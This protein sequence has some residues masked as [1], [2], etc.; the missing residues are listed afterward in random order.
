[1]S[2]GAAPSDRNDNMPAICVKSDRRWGILST[3]GTQENPWAPRQH[4]NGVLSTLKYAFLR[5]FPVTLKAVLHSSICS[6]IV[7]F[8]SRLRR[9]RRL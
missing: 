9:L 7:I 5:S 2:I 1:M 3:V 8:K 6:A 4:V